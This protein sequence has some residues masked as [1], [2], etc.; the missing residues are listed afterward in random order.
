MPLQC[1]V[2]FYFDGDRLIAFIGR[3]TD[4]IRE[5]FNP[6]FGFKCAEDVLKAVHE[7]LDAKTKIR[8]VRHKN[9]TYPLCPNNLFQFL[10]R[11]KIKRPDHGPHPR[12]KD[13]DVDLIKQ[14]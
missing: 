6:T 2:E 3:A 11:L 10:G 12:L 13:V 9:P 7:L 5:K 4:P 8:V 14:L 1:Y